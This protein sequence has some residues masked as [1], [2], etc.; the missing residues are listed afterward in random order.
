[1]FVVDRCCCIQFVKSREKKRRKTIKKNKRALS[2]CSFRI[3]VYV[4]CAES[5]L[6]FSAFQWYE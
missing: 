2:Q 4:R 1:M 5:P 3:R 6:E